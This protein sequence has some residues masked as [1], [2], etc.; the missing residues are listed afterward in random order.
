MAARRVSRTRRRWPRSAPR[1]S[2]S[3]ASTSMAP[4]ARRAQWLCI[5]RAGVMRTP[6]KGWFHGWLA[7]DSSLW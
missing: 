4:A 3:E 1:H 6:R 5:E 2:P 7:S